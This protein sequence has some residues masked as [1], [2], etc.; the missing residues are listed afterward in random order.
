M[1]RFF[2]N[3]FSRDVAYQPGKALARLMSR[4]LQRRRADERESAAENVESRPQGRGEGS[5]SLTQLDLGGGARRLN[6]AA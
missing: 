5:F 4:N 6:R 2:S 1:F 3:W